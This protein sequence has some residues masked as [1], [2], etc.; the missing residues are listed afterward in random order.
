[1]LYLGIDQH[2]K[3]LAVSVR[4]EVGGLDPPAA[5]FDG[6]G[7][8]ASVFDELRRLAEVEGGFV[9]I[10]EVC[11]FNDWLLKMLSEYGCRKTVLIQIE[12]RSGR[13]LR[14][15]AMSSGHVGQ[16]LASGWPLFRPVRPLLRPI[17][18]S[19]SAYSPIPPAP[20]SDLAS[21]FGLGI[22]QPIH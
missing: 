21:F 18:Q 3:Q 20:T 7:S 2:R 9:A 19:G 12:K 16:P 14:E 8:R 6:M 15:K 5:G 4:S 13:F 1:M 10:V 22:R 11:G 17:D